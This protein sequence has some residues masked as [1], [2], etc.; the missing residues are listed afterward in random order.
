MP[1]WLSPRVRLGVTASVIVVSV[2]TFLL[3]TG[4][5]DS[6]SSPSSVATPDTEPPPPRATATSLPDTPMPALPQAVITALGLGS[7]DS[8]TGALPD[9][10][11]STP[12]NAASK[13]DRFESTWGTDASSQLIGLNP[14][15]LSGLDAASDV[16][17][18]FVLAEQA[19]D[20]EWP[21]CADCGP[22]GPSNLVPWGGTS[23]PGAGS[24][25]PG[26]EVNLTE[27]GNPSAE[28][29]PRFELPLPP[30]GDPTP[31]P[32]DEEPL[33]KPPVVPVP[34]PSSATL[35]G[36][37]LSLLIGATRA[38]KRQR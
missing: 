12:G 26:G 5:T 6:E 28:E 20:L 24:G 9:I 21:G 4:R 18:E 38:R 16:F 36:A 13:G 2:C 31:E 32:P 37:A 35:M 11:A 14:D 25:A 8:S 10:P 3:T 23:L 19:I 34:E 22:Q 17:G 27:L 15:A 33:P 29:I 30:G 1:T 7:S